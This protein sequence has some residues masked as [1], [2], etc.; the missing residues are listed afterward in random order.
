MS[1]DITAYNQRR[2]IN[3]R[4]TKASFFYYECYF[5]ETFGSNRK[6]QLFYC[7]TPLFIL[8]K[9]NL[10]LYIQE[11]FNSVH[12]NIIIHPT[13]LRCL[14]IEVFQVLNSNFT[15]EKVYGIVKINIVLTVISG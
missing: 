10:T 6:Y 11:T 5:T 9:G 12:I 8:I 1:G 7:Y 15:F 2:Q 4:L 13:S 3:I 14:L